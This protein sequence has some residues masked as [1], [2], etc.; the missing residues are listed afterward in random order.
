M[1]KICFSTG[2]IF[3]IWKSYVELEKWFDPAFPE[4]INKEIVPTLKNA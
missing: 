4:F 1:D 2:T 3:D